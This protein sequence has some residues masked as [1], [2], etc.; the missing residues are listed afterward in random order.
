MSLNLR[1]DLAKLSDQ[2]LALRLDDA[3]REYQVAKKNEFPL[4]N[5]FFFLWPGYSPV[6]HP[7]LY[8]F[9]SIFLKSD[10]GWLWLIL[11]SMFSRK[12]AE[13]VIRKFDP[14][15]LDLALC[16]VRDLTAELERRVALKK[17]HV[18]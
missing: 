6:R 8:R 11:A 9:L 3:W 1:S 12:Q 13:S 18:T 2:G 10:G 16:E 7:R 4:P 5:P 15:D 14:I 17:A